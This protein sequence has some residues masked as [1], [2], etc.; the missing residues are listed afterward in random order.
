MQAYVGV[1]RGADAEANA[2]IR[3][4]A[5]SYER[6]VVELSSFQL[7]GVEDFHP[8]VAVLLNITEDHLDR[9]ATFQEYIDAKVRIEV[10]GTG[11]ALR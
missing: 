10:V 4:K 2:A 5:H 6:V 8:R 3:P 1:R 9:Y 11:V 7:E